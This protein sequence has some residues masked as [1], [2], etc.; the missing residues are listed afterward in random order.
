MGTVVSHRPS[1]SEMVRWAEVNW[2]A[3]KP[4]VTQLKPGMFI[5]HF[6]T[7]ADKLAVLGKHWTFYHKFQMV[8]KGWS[9]EEGVEEV[10]MNTTPVWI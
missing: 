3:F 6:P 9:V 10:T 1:Y 4:T 2:K 7:E 5:F 8:V